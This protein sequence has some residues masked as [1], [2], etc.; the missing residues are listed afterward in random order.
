MSTLNTVSYDQFFDIPSLGN[1]SKIIFSEEAYNYINKLI[2]ETK[3]NNS[4]NGCFL[5]GRSAVTS[6]GALCFYFDF[7]TSK[8][9]LVD[10]NYRNGAVIPTTNN[11][12]EL[13]E[14]LKKYFSLKIDACIMH[15]HAHNLNGLYSS[16]S[17]QDYGVYA[18]MK[19]RYKCETFGMLAAPN[20]KNKNDTIELSI[21]NCRDPKIV[22]TRACANFYLIPNIYY[23]KGNQ[24][25][26]VG[27]FNKNEL[28]SK[29]RI[30]EIA[31][32]DRFVQN[33]REW[34][35]SS[36][37]SG[38][39]KNPNTDLAI[40]DKVVGY[41]DINDSLIFADENLTLQFPSLLQEK[42]ITNKL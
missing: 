16:I 1:K 27:S 21:V 38:I 32:L 23:C 41:M 39:G 28:N 18:T 35:G 19:Q 6:D 8:F 3:N 12:S 13:I 25:M 37:V 2:A 4:E 40:E 30:T 36:L 9:L 17:D 34:K 5:V 7:F 42:S 15:F 10:G 11:K 26:K 33:Y 24:I 14:E 31:S 22:G 20:S 29:T